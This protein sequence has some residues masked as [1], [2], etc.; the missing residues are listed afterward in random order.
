MG[1]WSEWA[2]IF[3]ENHSPNVT[4]VLYSRSFLGVN[5]IDMPAAE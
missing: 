3:V 1:F 2:N 5:R 4:D